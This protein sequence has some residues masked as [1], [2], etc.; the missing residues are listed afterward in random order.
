MSIDILL[1]NLD[2]TIRMRYLVCSADI[3]GVGFFV[4]VTQRG[5][6]TS[7]HSEQSRKTP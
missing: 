4:P 1:E 2:A 7:S 6:T 5:G 3:L